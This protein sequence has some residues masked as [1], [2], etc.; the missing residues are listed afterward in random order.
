MVRV[1]AT[2]AAQPWLGELSACATQESAVL[3]LSDP[4]SADIFL[5]V[6]EP[7][8]LVMPAFQLGWDE[9]QVIV[10]SARS[11]R[12]L[13]TEQVTELFT[14][15]ISDWGQVTPGETG[16]VQV[17]VFSAGDD[18]QQAFAKTLAGR[19]IASNARMAASPAEMSRAIAND[20]NAVGIVSR[21]WKTGNVSNVY[22]AASVP[23]LAIT[24]SEPHGVV[25]NLLGCLQG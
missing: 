10:N 24:P 17:W 2:S 14:G 23:V 6:G 20:P 11:A 5:R 12:Q 21:R 9:I 19:P 25:K 22:V 3:F 13:Q 1:Y 4:G 16:A 18:A 15:Q 7:Q 8:N